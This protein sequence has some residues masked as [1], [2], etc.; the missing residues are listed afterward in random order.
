MST[1]DAPSQQLI[2]ACQEL[3]RLCSAAE[4]DLK[5]ITHRTVAQPALARLI[6]KHANSARFGLRNPVTDVDRA[7]SLLGPSHVREL[8]EQLLRDRSRLRR[9]TREIRE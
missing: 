6:L 8:L 1:G 9:L 4:P 5:G 3:I 7:V 2:A